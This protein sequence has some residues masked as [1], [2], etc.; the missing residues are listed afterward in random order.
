V[1]II[2]KYRKKNK[3]TLLPAVSL[4]RLNKN[5]KKLPELA[6]WVEPIYTTRAKRGIYLLLRGGITEEMGHK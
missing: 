2:N 3:T 5:I 4:F 6:G 1:E